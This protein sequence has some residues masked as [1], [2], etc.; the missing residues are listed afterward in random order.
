[1]HPELLRSQGLPTE[2]RDEKTVWDGRYRSIVDMEKHLHRNGTR[3][4]RQL[5]DS[6]PPPFARATEKKERIVPC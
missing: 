4:V 5:K 3:I 1:M 2:L 6:Q